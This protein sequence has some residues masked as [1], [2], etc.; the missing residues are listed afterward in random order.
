MGWGT[1]ETDGV[2]GK[3]PGHTLRRTRPGT[4]LGCGQDPWGLEMNEKGGLQEG[5][6]FQRRRVTA[7]INNRG[8]PE[9]RS[10][11]KMSSKLRRNR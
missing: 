10:I 5:R 6:V 8:K 7:E 1:S 9:Y 4:A 11:K 2:E 3:Q